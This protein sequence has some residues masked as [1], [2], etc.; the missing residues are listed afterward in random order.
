MNQQSRTEASSV[1]GRWHRQWPLRIAYPYL[2]SVVTALSRFLQ[3][4]APARHGKTWH[5]LFLYIV[6][7]GCQ[8]VLIYTWCILS[9]ASLGFTLSVW[10]SCYLHGPDNWA[11]SQL[12]WEVQDIVYISNSLLYLVIPCYL[13]CLS[14]KV[15]LIRINEL[16]C[17]DSYMVQCEL[18]KSWSVWDLCHLMHGPDNWACTQWELRS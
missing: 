4:S 5:H 3:L 2:A 8:R 17:F 15:C 11:C 13:S 1:P 14:V 18:C 6:C 16:S 7:V 12:N 10:D 9:Y